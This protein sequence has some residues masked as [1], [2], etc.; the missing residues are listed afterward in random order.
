MT[1]PIQDPDAQ[2]G[3]YRQ[4]AQVRQRVTRL[5]RRPAV[6]GAVDGAGVVDWVRFDHDNGAA[7][8]KIEVAPTNLPLQLTY[9]D[10]IRGTLTTATMEADGTLNLPGPGFY[11][12]QAWA[13]LEMLGVPYGYPHDI[14][15]ATPGSGAGQLKFT[16][17]GP[18]SSRE[19]YDMQVPWP[20]PSGFGTNGTIEYVWPFQGDGDTYITACVGE[21]FWSTGDPVAIVT[22]IDDY[23]GVHVDS[24]VV[25]TDYDAPYGAGAGVDPIDPIEVIDQYIIAFRLSDE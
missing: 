14:T 8:Q 7:N 22:R 23:Q 1:R 19:A 25:A 24:A 13:L 3:L 5:E 15:D 16:L 18:P 4:V 6:D 21:V 11:Y 17:S 9:S 2:P 20:V 10:S 12:V